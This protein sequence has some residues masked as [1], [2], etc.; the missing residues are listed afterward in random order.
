[1]VPRVLKVV[2]GCVYVQVAA[3]AFLGVA[4]LVDVFGRLGHGQRV[5]ETQVLGLIVMLVVASLMLWAAVVLTRGVEWGRQCLI[6]MEAL[7]GLI[8]LVGAVN[9][10]PLLLIVVALAGFA[11]YALSSRVVSSW[12]AFKAYHRQF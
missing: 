11:I 7:V 8:A 1:M 3:F 2:L 6:A 4:A 10:E 5:Q 12:L 9:G